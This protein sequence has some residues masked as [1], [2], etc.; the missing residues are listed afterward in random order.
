MARRILPRE[1]FGSGILRRRFVRV[2]VSWRRVVGRLAQQRAQRV[3]TLPLLGLVVHGRRQVPA[4]GF[5]CGVAGGR[6]FFRFEHHGSFAKLFCPACRH[7]RRCCRRLWLVHQ[8]VRA[9]NDR[10]RESASTR[11]PG[12]GARSTANRRCST[13]SADYSDS[14]PDPR[15]PKRP[16]DKRRQSCACRAA[17]ARCDGQCAA[18]GLLQCRQARPDCPRKNC[19]A[20]R[21][22]GHCMAE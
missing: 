11:E 2:L 7:C 10:A 8:P 22:T 18:T 13:T 16:L 17:T 5:K 14:W 4:A 9:Q 21:V 1:Y 20:M 6:K 12:I 19:G 3:G 15:R